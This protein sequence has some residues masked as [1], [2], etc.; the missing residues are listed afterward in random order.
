[1]VGRIWKLKNFTENKKYPP[2]VMV[3]DESATS[4]FFLDE[5]GCKVEISKFMLR[6]H[7]I[8]TTQFADEETIMEAIALLSE[9]LLLV[10]K[11]KAK[12]EI[13]GRVSSTSA[14]LRN[15]ADKL[16]PQIYKREE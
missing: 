4:A 14:K 5:E 2:E 13:A 6:F 9:L 8:P 15:L 3:I 11:P 16:N 7:P 12:K 1:M 10:N